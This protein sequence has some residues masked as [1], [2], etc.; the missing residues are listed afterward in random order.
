MIQKII[1]PIIISLNKYYYE[2]LSNV[3]CSF[4]KITSQSIIW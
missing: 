3:L 1:S 4:K 2:D